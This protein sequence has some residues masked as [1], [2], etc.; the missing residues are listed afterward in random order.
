M[1]NEIV[2]AVSLF[3][4]YSAV[5]LFYRFFGKTGLYIWTAI[6]AVSANIEALILVDAFGLEQTLGNILFASTFLVTDILS[7]TEGRRYAGKAVKIGIAVNIAFLLISQSWF[8][9]EPSVSDW[10]SPAIRE[11]FSHTPRLMIA[12]LGVYAIVQAFDVFAYHA[13]WKHTSKLF[14]SSRKGLWIRNNGATLLS[15]LMNTVLFTFCA[16]W[17][18]YSLSTLLNICA[19]SYVVFIA[20]SILDTPVV[21]IARRLKE[22]GKIS[23]E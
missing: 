4:L 16:F 10:A 18:T 19:S 1:S 7:E 3:C 14:G 2:L 21:Y 11:I 15:Q 6:A 13:I 12:S 20:T 23:S 17:G 5:V 9:Y 8:L 22:R